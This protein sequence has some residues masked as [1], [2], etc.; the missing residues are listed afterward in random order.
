MSEQRPI[1]ASLTRISDLDCVPFEIQKLPR[2]QWETGDYVVGSV[3][4]VSNFGTQVE[5]A[6][7][8]MMECAFG[9]LVVGA[10]G[11]RAATLEA[12]GSWQ[13]IGADG[14]MQAL[15]GAG[16]MGR[17]TSISPYM[18][19][20]VDLNYQGHVVRN[21]QKIRMQ[22]FVQPVAT[23]NYDLPTVLI[24]G[25]SMSSGKTTVG[26]VIVRQLSR[27]GLKVA[28][29]KLTG[30]G[31][32]RDTLAM[33][34]AGAEIIYDFV[35]AGLP[36][37]VCSPAEYRSALSIVLQ[38]LTETG[39][40]IVIAEAGASP[41]EP[42]SGDVLIEEIREQIKFTVLCASDPYAVVGV[43]QG[44]GFKPDLVA[45]IATTTSSAV[46]LVEKLSGIRALNLL[47]PESH[48][49]LGELLKTKLDV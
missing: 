2:D 17:A 29:V 46:K 8:R 35:D 16:L 26:K 37:T 34:D 27:K 19:K 22:D 32:F 6:N 38:K 12:V 41:L 30:A 5:L 28:A 9:D 47:D 48:P 10:L 42:Y 33:R 4:S 21:A 13:D 45:G 20:L 1:F 11:V 36:S 14:A 49:E 43:T 7:G 24:I 44:F 23:T 39:P 40:D 15:T 31:R 3:T 25:T 18:Q